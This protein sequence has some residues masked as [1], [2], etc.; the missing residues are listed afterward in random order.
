MMKQPG[1]DEDRRIRFHG[2]HGP[3][4]IAL[5]GGPGA[6]GGAVRLARGLSREFRVIE[7]WQ[8]PSGDMP[9]TVA[10]H[11]EDLHNLILSRFNDER[12]ALVGSSWGAMLALAY[13]AEHP[14]SITAIVLVG[15]GTFDKA[16]RDVIVRKRRRKIV[17]HI[18]KHP[19]HKA[20]L[21]LD[22]GEQMMKWHSMTDVYE[23]VADSDELPEA[24][25]FDMQGHTETWHDM[26]R[27]Q[28]TGV[29][30]QSFISIGV[31]AI[32]LHGADDPHPGRMTRDILSQYIPHL[33]YH[34][35]SRCGH[36]PE[37]EKYA[38]DEFF[39]I[40]SHWLRRVFSTTHEPQQG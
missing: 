3:P 35:F 9:L 31:P 5:H 6:F 11:V 29:Y 36:D 2:D 15:C 14:D 38:K 22:I 27:C 21:R 1:W 8:R 16:S 40:M 19:E 17:D 26:V 23:A 37:I 39:A 33:E 24:E 7:P 25:P 30:P 10:V 18:S 32:M 28:Q 20:D 13:A 34:E 4:V 12:P